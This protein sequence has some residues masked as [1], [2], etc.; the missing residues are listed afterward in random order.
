MRRLVLAALLAA[1]VSIASAG[2]PADGSATGAAPAACG[3]ASSAV[4]ARVDAAVMAAVARRELD[5]SE[6]AQ[7]SARV[8][9]STTLLAAVAARD[10]FSTWL[11]VH[12][13]VYHPLWHIVRLRVIDLAG[14]VLADIGGPHVASPVAGALILEGRTV[15]RFVMSV[16]DDAG[17]VKLEHAFIGD[18]AGIYGNG[19][20]IVGVPPTLPVL[21]AK[22]HAVLRGRRLLISSQPLL[23]FPRG[24]VR[25]SLLVPRPPAIVAAHTCATVRVEEIG[26]VAEHLARRF[27]PLSGNYPSFA[28][29]TAIYTRALVFVRSGATQLASSGPNGPAVLPRSGS[30]AYDGGSWSVFSFAPA[31]P[32]RIYVLVGP[33]SV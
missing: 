1:A 21:P 8:A 32:A 33:G 15:G 25:L 31:P 6:V 23:A 2:P 3:A 20:L 4:T 7:D 10:P 28:L 22:G 9:G 12:A 14:T 26:S 13:L 16:Q 11:A 5:G 30:V 19:T 27:T 18:D 29:T 17:V 24:H